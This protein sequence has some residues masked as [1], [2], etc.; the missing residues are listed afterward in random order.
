[1]K[2]IDEILESQIGNMGGEEA[3]SEEVEKS[4]THS[5]KRSILVVRIEIK[6]KKK[7]TTLQFE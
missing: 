3:G 2:E 5:V 4:P 7:V 1:M 6:K